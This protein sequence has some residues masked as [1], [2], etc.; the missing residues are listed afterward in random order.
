MKLHVLHVGDTKVP[1]GQFYGGTDDQWVGV[2]G[3]L[4][5]LRDKSHFITVPIHAFLVEHP[6][7]GALLVD[8][9]ITWR[10]A[11]DHRAYYDGPLLR[12]AFDEDEYS[13][14]EGQ[15]LLG[16]LQRRG[17]TAA[18]VRT[19]V[20]THLHED[21]LGGVRD[22]LGARFLVSADD[23]SARNLGIFPFRRTPSLKGV[24]T[25]PEQVRFTGPPVGPFPASHDVL[26][27]GSVVLLPTPGHSA[28]H[29][30]VLIDGGDWRVLC[31]G[32]TLYT[33]RHLDSDRIRPI[34]LGRRA[35]DR[36]LD[37]IER[38]RRLRA[39]LPGLVPA[40]GHDHTEYGRALERIFQG[41]PDPAALAGLHAVEAALVTPDGR[42]AGPSRPAYRPA[43]A[44]SAVG[45]VDFGR[46]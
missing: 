18:D 37:S 21:H 38:I 4:R 29:L 19:V 33:L 14:E 16:H 34:M 11:H 2:R 36:Q 17:L 12:A 6:E 45:T 46:G 41:D 25:D 28:G 44:G 7:H 9:G 40:P 23:W 15:Q 24:L 31:V 27:D 32:D 3:M 5:F 26:G 39:E 20:L 8:T 30:S 42:L 1:Y 43:P 35:R 13:L 10:Q 22:L